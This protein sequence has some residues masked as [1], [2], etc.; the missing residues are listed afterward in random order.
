L[1]ECCFVATAKRIAVTE[2][3]RINERALKR[4]GR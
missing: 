4:H 3:E 1:A 2:G